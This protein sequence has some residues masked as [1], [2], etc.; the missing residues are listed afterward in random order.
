METP[1]WSRGRGPEEKLVNYAVVG[2][3][4][5]RCLEGN[6]CVVVGLGCSIVALL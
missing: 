2:V 1:K 5:R 3:A 4:L 6:G